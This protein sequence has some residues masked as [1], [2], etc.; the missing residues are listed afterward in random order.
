MRKD[1]AYL[2]LEERKHLWTYEEV[3]KVR[4][5]HAHKKNVFEIAELKNEDPDDVALVLFDQAQQ[6]KLGG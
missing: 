6:G 3:L 2:V 4:E 1:D 5:Y